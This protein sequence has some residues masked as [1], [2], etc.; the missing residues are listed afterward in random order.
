MARLQ[1]GIASEIGVYLK[2]LRPEN[3]QRIA[4]QIVEA[5]LESTE[6]LELALDLFNLFI[7]KALD[8]PH[9]CK[10]VVDLVCTLCKL[11]S[12]KFRDELRDAC[13]HGLIKV[14]ENIQLSVTAASDPKAV[15]CQRRDHK[16]M[17][18]W[19]RLVG[20]L[21]V[22]HFL[23]CRLIAGILLQILDAR[24]RGAVKELLVECACELLVITGRRWQSLPRQCKKLPEVIS[25][26][27]GA[28]QRLDESGEVLHGDRVRSLVQDIVQAHEEGACAK[29]EQ[30]ERKRAED[31]L[32]E[33][34]DDLEAARSDITHLLA[35]N[36]ELQARAEAAEAKLQ[37]NATALS[38]CEV[39][40]W[41]H[42][43]TTPTTYQQPHLVAVATRALNE[44]VPK[45]H[46]QP[47]ACMQRAKVTGV[48]RVANTHLWSKYKME[49]G[50][51]AE[52]IRHRS[53]C[54]WVTEFASGCGELNKLFKHIKL[55]KYAN[56]VLLLHG[57][58]EESIPYIVEHGFDERLSRRG[59]YGSGVYFTF[60]SCKAAQYIG[61]GMKGT[62]IL[63][64]VI[65]GRPFLAEGPLSR[66]PMLEEYK[67]PYDST[68]VRPGISKGKG[69][70]GKRQ[71]HWEFVVQR[72]SL[73]A[74]PELLIDFKLES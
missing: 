53:E 18:G 13:R 15:E 11:I 42:G 68:I 67:T 56:E 41:R 69:K 50:Q 23:P 55:E 22:S 16:R 33:A 66:T 70:G 57:S 36:K 31:E 35:Q 52:R 21:N 64:R 58:P 73:Q 10:A 47:C 49:R 62:L 26:L 39:E 61:Q 20:H 48:R 72:G 38:D 71:T 27:E 44:L 65:L 2:Q 9:C 43:L 32:W 19:M 4:G 30:L 6:K 46:G 7:T 37:A 25:R 74:Y 24:P 8:E 5:G 63:S 28:M 14:L 34:T 29:W 40:A 1:E 60:E 59:L 54:P 45:S 51:I 12:P 3:V 17:I